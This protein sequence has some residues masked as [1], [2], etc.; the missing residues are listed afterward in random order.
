MLGYTR[1][2]MLRL[3]CLDITHPEDVPDN[4]ARVMSLLSGG[5]PSYSLEKRYLRKDGST[6]WVDMSV[7]LQRDEAGRPAYAIEISEDISERKR[8]EA[9]LRQAKE[10]AEA[11]NRAKDEFLTNVSHE[12]RT[13][14]GAILGMTELVLDSPLNEDQRECLETA[15]SAAESLLALV[16]DLLDFGK[17]EAGKLQLDPA[18]FSLRAALGD[19]VR[20]LVPRAVKKGLALNWHVRPEVPD[21]LAGDAGRLRQVLTNLVGNAIK[22]TEQGEVVVTVR[23][24]IGPIGPI[25]PISDQVWLSFDGARH[26]HRHRPR[27][28]RQDLPGLRAGGQ[29]DNAQVRGHRPGTYHR[30]PAGDAPGR[31][32]QR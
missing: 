25:G 31:R 9:E 16:N 28:A 10:L 11:A 19:T 14:F 4:R 7:S 22:F 21:A 32:D 2:E 1:E 8:L 12:I 24:E 6:I 20:A 13:P 27:K 3:T 18:D 23:P 5:L 30:L 15:R 29:F 26:G 17:I